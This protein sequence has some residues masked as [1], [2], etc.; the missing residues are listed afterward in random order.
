MENQKKIKAKNL[1]GFA[2]AFAFCLG[3]LIV[4]ISTD[5]ADISSW[6]AFWGCVAALGFGVIF[7]PA[8]VYQMFK[9]QKTGNSR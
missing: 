9:D 2:V 8:K 4:L 6:W 1:I 5:K 3:L 7:I